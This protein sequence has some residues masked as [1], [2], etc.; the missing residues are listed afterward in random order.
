MSLFSDILAALERWDRWRVVN[1]TPE[2]VDAM[3]RR[4]AELEAK[5]GDEWPADVC[6]ACGKRA[7]RLASSNRNV[8][9]WH[10]QECGESDQ[11]PIGKR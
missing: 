6:R 11:R 1:A 9:R 7:L 4:V 10:C 3:E 5:L 8:E 2:R